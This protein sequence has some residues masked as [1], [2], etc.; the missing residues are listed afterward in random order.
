MVHQQ[1][2]FVPGQDFTKTAR[3][4]P[5]RVYVKKSYLY[6]GGAIINNEW[7]PGYEVGDPIVPD[8]HE[9]VYDIGCGWEMNARPPVAVA[10]LRP[11]K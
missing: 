2:F 10:V 11:K 4:K 9:L 5:V 7:Y 8:T 3:S 6:N 1:P